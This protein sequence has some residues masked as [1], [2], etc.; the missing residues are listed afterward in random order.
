MNCAQLAVAAHDQNFTLRSLAG[1]RGVRKCPDFV[2]DLTE[3]TDIERR[4]Y[5]QEIAEAN[6]ATIIVPPTSATATINADINALK[7]QIRKEKKPIEKIALMKQLRIKYRSANRKA[8]ATKTLKDM[9]VLALKTWKN[10]PKKSKQKNKLQELYLEA[11]T[12]YGRQL[13]AEDEHKKSQRILKG[14]ANNLKNENLNEVYFLLGRVYEE[15]KKYSQALDYYE[16]TLIELKKAPSKNLTITREKILWTKAWL[17]YKSENWAKAA[18]A[19]NELATE[20]TDIA[21]KSRAHF[22]YSRALTRLDKKEEAKKILMNLTEQDF[23]SYYSL[24][25]YQEMGLKVPAFKTLKSKDKFN[26]D[27]KLSFLSKP[28]KELFTALI[29]HDEADLAERAAQI[30]TNNPEQ[31]A[32]L[33]LELARRLQRYLPLFA[34][35]AKLPV[36]QK[37]DIMVEKSELLFPRLY[38]NEVQEMATITGLP[39]SL[40]YSIM[41]QESAFNINSRSHANAYGLMQ[42]I[43]P[44]AKQLARKYKLDYKTPEDLFNPQINI[45]LGSFELSEQVRKQKDQYTLV[46]AAY[47]A[48]PMAVA[49]WLK[50]RWRPWFDVVDFIEEI[51]YD[52]TRLYVKVIARNHLFYDRLEAPNKEL[53]FPEKF[54]KKNDLLSQN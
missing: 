12:N 15:I 22:F 45:K 5:L 52:E 39:E 35:F 14:V 54:I 17:L 19:L 4:V 16:K 1:I 38:R 6:Q 42:V 10:E 9:H 3:V 11:A 28:Q 24:L 47:N 23:Y 53:D 41:R 8:D 44:L 13:W 29:E 27:S 36:E 18:E 48:G 37:Q 26:F 21:E 32:I 49:R 20:T 31:S 25:A 7:T 40:I 34:S 30:F 50:T 33:G 51:P 43:P 2:Y 46:A